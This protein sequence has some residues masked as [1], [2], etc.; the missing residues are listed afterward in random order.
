MLVV[1]VIIGILAALGAPTLKGLRQANL[2]ASANRQ[3]LDDLSFARIRAL[4]D[5]TT[6]YMVFIPTNIVTVLNLPALRPDERRI[7]SNLVLGQYSTYALL[8][9][10]TVGD[11]PGQQTPRYLT[12][13]RSLPKGILIPDVKFLGPAN[14]PV[15]GSPNYAPTVRS[16][17]GSAFSR[18]DGLPF[19]KA[20]SAITNVFLPY[21]GFN[22]QGQVVSQHDELIPLVRGTISVK[23]DPA[24]GG[25]AAKAA[26][27]N[28]SPRPIIATN[29]FQGVRVNWVTGRAKVEATDFQQ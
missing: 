20:R 13:W 26:D 29:D 7:V 3:L 18:R 27:P 21:I 2:V 15:L 9:L 19:P 24:K 14:Y 28:L 10:R 8:T 1:I 17:F 16:A 6:V 4:S 5:R 25:F 12:E 22:A 23:R 11:Q